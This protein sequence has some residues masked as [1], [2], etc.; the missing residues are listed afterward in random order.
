MPAGTIKGKPKMP[1]KKR[2]FDPGLY[3]RRLGPDYAM[4]YLTAALAND[5]GADAIHYLSL[6][7]FAR[8]NHLTYIAGSTGIKR[9]DLFKM[10][11]RR[12]IHGINSLKATVNAIGL[13]LPT[14]FR[15]TKARRTV[16]AC[17]RSFLQPGLRPDR[18][19]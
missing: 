3:K 17:I 2:S 18:Q 6:L 7:D 14:E 8:A 12:G 15:G 5:A 16:A 4:Q 10:L 9:E 19:P 1:I 13:R 11:P